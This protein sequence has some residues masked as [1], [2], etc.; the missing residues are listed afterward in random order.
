MADKP[1][2]FIPEEH[3]RPEPGI[4]LALI[5]ILV[6]LGVTA[7][8][9]LL[10]YLLMVAISPLEPRKHRGVSIDF[11]ATR[12]APSQP[13]AV[14]PVAPGSTA[15]PVPPAPGGAPGTAQGQ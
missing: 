15:A 7:I 13:S 9:S 4:G 3:N 6:M 11:P 5:T 10:I 1:Q 2:P 12:S 8:L 14:A